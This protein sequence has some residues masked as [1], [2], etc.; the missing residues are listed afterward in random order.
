MKDCKRRKAERDGEGEE[1]SERERGEGGGEGGAG[2]R[3]GGDS[4]MKVYWRC[5]FC[6]HGCRAQ[7][8]ADSRL[9]PLW[10]VFSA[11]VCKR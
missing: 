8:N 3:G 1:D 7:E 6:S 4:K 11:Q 2:G 9:A 10:A 5:V